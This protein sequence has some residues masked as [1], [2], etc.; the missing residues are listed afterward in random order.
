MES[1]V[2]VRIIVLII[3]LCLSAFF[4]SAETAL[5]TVSRITM[6]RL[7]EDGDKRARLV[8]KI[9]DNPEKMLSAIL[10]GNNLVNILASAMATLLAVSIFGDAG[11]GIATGVLTLLILIFG[12]VTPKTMAAIRAERISLL[13]SRVIWP[14]MVVLTPVI[15]VVNHLAFGV[16]RLLHVD[17]SERN[18]VLTERE[19]RTV[20]EVSS[21]PGEIETE[22]KQMLN[23]VFDFDESKVE[24]IMVPRVDMTCVRA[25]SDYGEVAEIIRSNQ[26]KYTR[27]P[28]LDESGEEVVGILNMKDMVL[29]DPAEFSVRG[30]MRKPYF[31]YTQE[32]ASDLM[33]R[34]QKTS[35]NMAIVLDEYGMIAGLITMEDLIEEI[36]G[37]IR[38][39]YDADEEEPLERISEREYIVSGSLSLE[40]FNKALSLQLESDGYNSIGGYMMNR[41]NRLVG[42]SDSVL[43]PD[44]VFLQV[45]TTDKHRIG[46]V[47]VR[48]PENPKGE[49]DAA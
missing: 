46:K 49:N 48:L 43:T 14:L 35:N 39:E 1:D 11:A 26:S 40:D 16:L 28:V 10:I 42:E 19:L 13:Y 27:L 12:E 23:N 17:P 36:V 25:D 22:E 15:F 29:L 32:I 18:N 4:S 34:M 3:L 37:E 44:G 41:L 47:Y 45:L 7:A 24:S 30:L 8:L 31:T 9:T 38:D 6:T 21:D 33:V 20:L 2:P 5:T